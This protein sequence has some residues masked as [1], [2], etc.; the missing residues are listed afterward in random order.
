M[1]KEFKLLSLSNIVAKG[2]L[3]FAIKI[4]EVHEIKKNLTDV[5]IWRLLKSHSDT[6][7]LFKYSVYNYFEDEF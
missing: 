1:L 2:K 5:L 7:G 4:Y 6:N 3:L